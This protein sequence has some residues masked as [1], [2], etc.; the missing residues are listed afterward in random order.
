MRAVAMRVVQDRV[1][2]DKTVQMAVKEENV[3]SKD[4]P[5]VMLC[6]IGVCVVTTDTEEGTLAISSLSC[7]TF[8]EF[9]S[10]SIVKLNMTDAGEALS[11][12]I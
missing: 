3:T 5:K 6:K 8:G 4:E 7:N 10:F 2:V 12:H 11:M 1:V 9:F